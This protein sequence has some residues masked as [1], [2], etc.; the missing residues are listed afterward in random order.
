VTS[1]DGRTYVAV[2]TRD[3]VCRSWLYKFQLGNLGHPTALT[4]LRV[5]TRSV[6]RAA[7]SKDSRTLALATQQ[8]PQG[9]QPLPLPPE[10]AV[11][12]LATRQTRQWPLP[13]PSRVS[14]I[15]LTA[16]GNLLAYTFVAGHARAAIYVLPANA[17]PGPALQRSRLVTAAGRF[18]GRDA[19]GTAVITPDGSS[20]Y[21]AT[22]P[23]GSVPAGHWQ[24]RAVSLATGRIRV[25]GRYAG[26]GGDLAA[27]PS[28]TR[29]LVVVRSSRRPAPSPSATPSPSPSPSAS[30]ALAGLA[31]SPS[32]SRHPTPR[33]TPSRHPTPRPTPTPSRHPTPQPT[34]SPTRRPA[35]SRLELISLSS[36]SPR[37]LRSPAWAPRAT[38]AYSW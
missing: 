11:V 16:N 37:I 27:D 31:V 38:L 28:V 3:G 10:I 23:A 6:T 2:L 29:V 1:G 19:I 13:H 18:A 30:K 21:F 36:G 9:R 17:D 33:P 25:V 24:L 32:P 12:N 8:C 7:L 34:P 14:S 35:S 20:I 5:T 22:N 26:A 15:S 4:A